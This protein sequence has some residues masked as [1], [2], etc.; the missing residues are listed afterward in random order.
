MGSQAGDGL[1]LGV[2]ECEMLELR[3]L[4]SEE[5]RLAAAIALQAWRDLRTSRKIIRR[6]RD[7]EQKMDRAWMA[8][9]MARANDFR[10]KIKRA[11]Q[12][13]QEIDSLSVVIYFQDRLWFMTVAALGMREDALDARFNGYLEEVKR[14][15]RL[16]MQLLRQVV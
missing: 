3:I 6:I 4:P 8:G 12:Q 9:D 2:R 7:W 5:K 16:N 14:F 13:L 1:H 10:L 11:I 15:W